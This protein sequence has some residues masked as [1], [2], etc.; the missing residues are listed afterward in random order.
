MTGHAASA[1]T[2]FVSK[3]SAQ[4]IHASCYRGPLKAMIWD[5][6]DGTFVEDLISFGYDPANAQAIATMLCRDQTLVGNPGR[7]RAALLFEIKRN[8]PVN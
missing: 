3:P 8:P 5:R 7:F 6:P 2:N 4:P 1:D